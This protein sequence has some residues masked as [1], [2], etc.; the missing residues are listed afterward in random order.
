MCIVR[1]PTVSARSEMSEPQHG[2][3]DAFDG[4]VVLFEDVVEVLDLA[5]LDVRAGISLP[6]FDSY[7]RKSL[8][9]LT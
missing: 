1:M 6:E 7:S 4:P 8:I 9:S 2:S 5:H 3:H